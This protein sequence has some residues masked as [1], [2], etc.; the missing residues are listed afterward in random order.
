MLCT[1]SAP[2]SKCLLFRWV[3][4]WLHTCNIINY[5]KIGIIFDFTCNSGSR[6]GL[7]SRVT[8]GFTLRTLVSVLFIHKYTKYIF[9]SLDSRIGL[10]RTNSVCFSPIWKNIPSLRKVTQRSLGVQGKRN[11]TACGNTW[12]ASW[13]PSDQHWKAPN[14]GKM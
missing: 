5:S 10:E 9:L 11:L 4:K 3:S 2:K 7:E 8:C 12:Q 14:N 13:I 6:V 1:F